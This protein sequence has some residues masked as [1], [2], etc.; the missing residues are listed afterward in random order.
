MIKVKQLVWD[1]DDG[2]VTPF[3]DY[4]AI[5][6]DGDPRW[7]MQHET[8]DGWLKFDTIDQA[9]AAAQSDFERRVMECLEP[10]Q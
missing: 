2:A 6:I 5:Q 7:W 9:K 4:H 10:D 8:M 3:G 1:D